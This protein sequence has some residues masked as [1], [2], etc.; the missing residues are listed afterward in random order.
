[1]TPVIMDAPLPVF[2]D[3]GPL[4]VGGT[5]L[6]ATQEQGAP[7]HRLDAAAQAR[8]TATQAEGSSGGADI[9]GSPT[10]ALEPDTG[11]P[12]VS[13]TATGDIPAVPSAPVGRNWWEG[14]PDP[15]AQAPAQHAPAITYAPP[16]PLHAEIV[17]FMY[18]AAPTQVRMGRSFSAQSALT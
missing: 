15:A 1:M 5:P 2:E 6:T 16:S 8:G 14:P 13:P 17:D 3:F 11:A 18:R 7:H 4:A 9:G 10:P 12:G